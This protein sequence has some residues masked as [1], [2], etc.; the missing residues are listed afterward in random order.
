MKYNNS[1]GV[2]RNLPIFFDEGDEAIIERME[3]EGIETV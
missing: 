3:E 1:I 2:I